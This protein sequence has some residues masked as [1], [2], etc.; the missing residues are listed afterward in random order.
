MAHWPTK[1]NR[2]LFVDFW[3]LFA[4]WRK[5]PGMA[6]KWGRKVFIPVNPD[7]AD[8]LGDMDFEFEICFLILLDSSFFGFPGSQI[9][10]T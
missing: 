4:P 10:K 1:E 8:M 5:W 2:P 9:F 6:S 3:D 7:L